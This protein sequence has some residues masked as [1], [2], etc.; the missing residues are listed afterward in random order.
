MGGRFFP[1]TFRQRVRR[2]SHFTLQS[3]CQ[4]RLASKME[5]EVVHLSIPRYPRLKTPCSGPQGL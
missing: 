2:R 1:A 3:P 5:N 4:A